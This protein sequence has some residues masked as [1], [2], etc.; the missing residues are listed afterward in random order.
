MKIINTI[1][2]NEN[3][4]PVL[5]N[6]PQFKKIADPGSTLCYKLLQ[7]N[8][9]SVNMS[10][11]K[12]KDILKLKTDAPVKWG[13]LLIWMRRMG[14]DAVLTHRG[15]GHQNAG[16]RVTKQGV[17]PCIAGICLVVER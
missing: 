10:D 4:G 1:K 3:R 16:C 9:E 8:C 2:F 17:C 5:T 12:P 11:I 13:F 14:Q 15:K 7:G 6:I